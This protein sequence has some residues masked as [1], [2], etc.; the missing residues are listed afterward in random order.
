MKY[1]DK[2][3]EAYTAEAK[4]LGNLLIASSYNLIAFILIMDEE[5]IKDIFKWRRDLPR[6]LL[7]LI[8]FG[9]KD[10]VSESKLLN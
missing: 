10:T 2:I 6:T 7:K 3:Y 1:R 8:V 9:R 5:T 4:G